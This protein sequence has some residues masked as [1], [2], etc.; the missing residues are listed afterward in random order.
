M[1]VRGG[2][3]GVWGVVPSCSG[4]LCTFVPARGR[5]SQTLRFPFAFWIEGIFQ[6]K[7][8]VLSSFFVL[9]KVWAAVFSV[10]LRGYPPLFCLLK[11]W[12]RTSKDG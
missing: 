7:L 5:H 6:R 8:F 10:L 4:G 9:S 11:L 3:G 1:R 12:F 2:V